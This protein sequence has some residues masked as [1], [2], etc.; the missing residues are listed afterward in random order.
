M[1]EQK[2]PKR[3]EERELN[4]LRGSTPLETGT[5]IWGFHLVPH[6]DQLV[7]LSTGMLFKDVKDTQSYIRARRAEAKRA[8]RQFYKEHP[9]RFTP[10]LGPKPVQKE[11]R[12]KI[13]L[14]KSTTRRNFENAVDIASSTNNGHISYNPRLGMISVELA[15]KD[16]VLGALKQAG[17]KVL[18][19]R[20]VYTR[21]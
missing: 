12:A 3:L 2:E 6:K 5:H 15:N 1:D 4:W 11:L 19:V 14:S 13:T 8:E 17:Y 18:K 21:W 10:G 16:A 20:E 9:E 7:D